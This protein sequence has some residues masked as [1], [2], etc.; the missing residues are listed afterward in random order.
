LFCSKAKENYMSTSNTFLAVFL[1]SKSSAKMAAWNE[2]SDAAR[3][4][5]EQEGIAAW[6]G[7][8]QRHQDAIVAMG[9]PL[10]KTKKISPNG[11]E[12]ITNAMGAFTVVRAESDAAAAKLF[13]DHPHFTIFPGES[14]EVMPVLPI[15]GA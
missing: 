13:L 4:A 8:A 3:K 12:D 5:R 9:G 6:K 15:P 10:G 11:I 14:I 2:L 1:G 7:W